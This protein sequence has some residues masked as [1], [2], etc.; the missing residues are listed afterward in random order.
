MQPWPRP[1]RRDTDAERHS[2]ATGKLRQK[3]GARNQLARAAV[4][5]AI[6]H[7]LQTRVYI[8]SPVNIRLSHKPT[9]VLLTCIFD[10][11]GQWRRSVLNYGGRVSQVKPSNCFRRLEKL[12][13]PSIFDTSLLSLMMSNLQSYPTTVLN[14][15]SAQRDAN[16][17]RA[18]CIVRFGHRP[19][20]RPPARCKHANTQT[21]PITIHCAAVS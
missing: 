10:Y 3:V 11:N 4:R 5:P 6:H 15:R 18:S 8:L 21:G 9:A 12:L 7:A 17:A 14:E 16:T 1:I 20:A 2:R 13:L 19:P